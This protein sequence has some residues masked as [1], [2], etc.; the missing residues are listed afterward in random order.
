MSDVVMSWKSHSGDRKAI[1]TS[2]DQGIASNVIMTIISAHNAMLEP[3]GLEIQ[4]HGRLWGTVA[5]TWT[6]LK[7]LEKVSFFRNY[8]YISLIEMCREE[9]LNIEIYVYKMRK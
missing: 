6:Q 8:K 3:Q 5:G 9:T 2:V 7:I 1:G 4:K